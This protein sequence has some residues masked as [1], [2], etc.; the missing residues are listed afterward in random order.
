MYEQNFGFLASFSN[1][2]QTTLLPVYSFLIKP[3][4]GGLGKAGEAMHH[5]NAQNRI[6]ET[7]HHAGVLKAGVLPGRL[8][9]EP[10]DWVNCA[11]DFLRKSL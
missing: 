5:K 6:A 2:P 10:P 4:P 9:V 3:C 8:E 1:I 7:P 11:V